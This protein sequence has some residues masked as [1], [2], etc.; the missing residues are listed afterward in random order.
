M[1]YL[2]LDTTY[3]NINS[4]N[5]ALCLCETRHGILK[6]CIALKQEGMKYENPENFMDFEKKYRKRKLQF[7]EIYG[8][9]HF[10]FLTQNIKCTKN[11]QNSILL[12]VGIPID[13]NCAP[14]IADLFLYCYERDFMSNLK[15]SERIDFIDTYLSI[16]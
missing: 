7:F 10:F 3:C 16:T 8:F 13:T 14:L 2:S 12:L 1:N 15:Q 11:S 5:I 9:W 4:N 6:E